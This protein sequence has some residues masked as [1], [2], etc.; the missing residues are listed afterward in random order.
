MQSD[1]PRIRVMGSPS[2]LEQLATYLMGHVDGYTGIEVVNEVSVNVYLAGAAE[3]DRSK[4]RRLFPSVEI[5][6]I[7]A[8]VPRRLAEHLRRRVSGDIRT[9]STRGVQ[10]MSIEI[11]RTGLVVIGVRDPTKHGRLLSEAYGHDCVRVVLGED[12]ED[13]PR[14]GPG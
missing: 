11:D 6:F 5:N 7:A 4:L 9:W 13:M 14:L 10:I 12:I 8:R 3:V 1:R 2:E